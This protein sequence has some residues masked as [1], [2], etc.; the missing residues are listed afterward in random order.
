MRPFSGS[1]NFDAATAGVLRQR[2]KIRLAVLHAPATMRALV[3]ADEIWLV[4]MAGVV[5]ATSGIVVVTMSMIAQFMHRTLYGL[6]HGE[7][8]SSQ[9]AVD[10]VRALLVPS[11]GGLALGVA[12][13]ATV[14][15]VSRRVVDPIEAN[16]LYGGSMSFKDSFVVVMQTIWSNGVGGSVGLEAGY[17]QIGSAIASRLG[18]LLPAAAV[19]HAAHGRVR[20]GRRDR[21]GLQ[22][23]ADRRLLCVRARH[24]HV[25]TRPRWRRS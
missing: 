2:R 18:P 25:F 11:L 24:R 13:I 8:L 7:Y 5:G 3:R 15:W 23:A 22:R 19:G 21:S 4:V 6:G 10:P 20:R 17:A 1:L 9:L 14:K 16:A 12:G